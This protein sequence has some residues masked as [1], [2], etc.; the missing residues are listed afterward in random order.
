MSRESSFSRIES[1]FLECLEIPPSARSAFLERHCPDDPRLREEV[2]D[3]I[4]REGAGA[5]PLPRLITA[6]PSGQTQ[7]ASDLELI[8]PYRLL[9][10]LGEGGF[11]EVYEA[12]QLAPVRR[13]VA[14]KVL[15]AG[16]D[17]KAVLA[18][19]EAER[20][21]LALMDHPA[22]AK[23]HDAGMTA[24]GRPYFV[25]E[26][27]GGKSITEYS[28][29]GSLPLRDRLTLFVAVCRA[30]EHAH[31]KG[32]I[33]RDIK[34]SNVLVSAA[35]GTHRP[36]IIDFGIA[37]ATSGAI[38]GE[39]L[40]TRAGDVLGTPE[41]MSPE[42]AGSGGIDVDTRTDV[43]SLGVVL[44]RLLTGRLP[45]DP[46][47]LRGVGLDE[48]QRTLREEEPLLP[49]QAVRMRAREESERNRSRTVRSD[50]AMDGALQVG[51]YGRVSA[52]VD[53]KDLR[54]DLDWIVLKAIEKDRERRYS[55]AAALADDVERHLRDVPVSAAAPSA[56]YRLSKFIRRHRP[57]VAVAAIVVIAFIAGLA[58]TMSLAA[59]AA[60][61]ILVLV[62]GLAATMM[63]SARARRAETKA[64]QQAEAA[65]AV[66]A[67]LTRMLVGANP[68]LTPGGSNATLREMV[69]RAAADLE[70]KSTLPPRVE[71]GI[72]QTLGS[73]YFGL[74]A[75]DAADRHFGRAVELWSRE[76]GANAPETIESRLAAAEVVMRRG[77]HSVAE[78]RLA[79]IGQ[80]IETLPSISPE[81]RARHLRL[82]GGNLCVL[83]RFEEA[84]SLLSSAVEMH[85]SGAN[86]TELA[87]SLLELSRVVQQRGRYD[88]ATDGAREA[89]GLMRRVHGGDHVHVASALGRLASALSARQEL[90]QAESLHRDTVAMFERLLGRIHATTAMALGNLGIALCDAGKWDEAIASQREAVETLSR[91]LGD[92]APETASAID[93][94]AVSLQSAGTLEEALSLRLSSLEIVRRTLGDRHIRMASTLN[95]LGALYRL[96][97]RSEE[98]IGAFQEA[99]D[100]YL[101]AYGD[102]HLMVAIV[103]NN[104]GM[105]KLDLN[106]AAEAEAHFISGLTV[107]GDAFP[108]GHPTI[109]LM[110]GNLGRALA[111]LD[112]NDEA[113][114]ELLA[115][116]ESASAGLGHAHP[117]TQ[118]LARDIAAFYEK[119]SRS[120]ESS[121]WKERAISGPVEG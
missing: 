95:N 84:E 33:H 14:V 91:T 118:T 28:D 1:L 3:L 73:T 62:A 11:G 13:R 15:K 114:R 24:S 112:R 109:G 101:H 51:S 43:Y 82:R 78:S 74:G 119:Q 94:L 81:L 108:A 9:Q 86:D 68:E 47:R 65:R 50:A 98:A 59:G 83:D 85:R 61:V 105:A 79:R 69:D 96:M 120:H 72:R 42:Q 102:R 52:L 93:N 18:R 27:V 7:E 49:S 41:Y 90:S 107:A 110:R 10:R 25:M 37:K 111:A 48:F 6:T 39:T 106:R 75:Y 4:E 22:I 53:A 36:R 116:Y 89:L 31:Q 71:A 115:A 2:L 99:H 19:F 57:L 21:T 113:E 121:V 5:K 70:E 64:R 76:L 46:G 17:S 77:Q 63:Q 97:Q 67:F 23:V 38:P 35:D 104:L 45:L 29:E 30:V 16:M 66:N 34:P 56:M 26:L 92:E 54:G 117:R 58:T 80:E 88:A 87:N 20:Q 100:I 40:H 12:E 103:Q 60:A 8:G 44:Y 32:I 55:S